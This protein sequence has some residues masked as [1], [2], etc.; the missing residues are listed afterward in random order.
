MT[1]VAAPAGSARPPAAP[2][3]RPPGQPRRTALFAHGEPLIWLTGGSLAIALLMIVG[4]LGYI[5][6]QGLQ[7]FWPGEVVLLHTRDGAVLGG[8]LTREESFTAPGA[9]VS[10]RRRL[11]R[12]GNFELTGEH[13]R[14]V[15]DADVASEARPEWFLAVERLTWGRFY[16]ELA[17]YERDGVAVATTPQAAWAE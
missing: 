14:W 10:Q 5:G 15:A 11:L 13:F 7:T 3:R 9:T 17:G 1:P 12:I 4:L 16:G 8:E 2:R 6:A